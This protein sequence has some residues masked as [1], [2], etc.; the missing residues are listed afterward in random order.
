MDTVLQSLL[1]I[2]IVVY[3]ESGFSSIIGLSQIKFMDVPLREQYV[4][5]TVLY[6]AVCSVLA[7]FALFLKEIQ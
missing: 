5:C 7:W 2:G 3:L 6:I 4:I 1:V